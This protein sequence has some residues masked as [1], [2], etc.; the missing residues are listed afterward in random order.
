MRTRKN[1]L[2]FRVNCLNLLIFLTG[3]FFGCLLICFGGI[4][5]L[6]TLERFQESLFLSKGPD[7]FLEALLTNG[8]FLALLY[9]LA[10]MRAGAILTPTLFGCEGILMGGTAAAV[11]AEM[12]CHGLML[13]A[14][15][16]LFR[17]CI[18][19]PYGFLLGTWSVGQSLSCGTGFSADQRSRVV[20]LLLTIAVLMAASFL[21]CTVAQWLARIYYLKVGV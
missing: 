5:G 18:L 12:G 4:G 1:S 19:L 7:V 2:T 8:K 3:V 11:A 15:L 17:L 13:L 10:Y 16:F 6:L 21:E 14:L 20:V 9:L